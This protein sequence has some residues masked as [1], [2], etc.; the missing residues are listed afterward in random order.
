MPR[1]VWDLGNTTVRN[2][3]RIQEGLIVFAKHFQGNVYGAEQEAAFTRKL[4]DEGIISTAG[5]EPSWFGRKWRNVFVKLGFVTDKFNKGFQDSFKELCQD[6]GLSGKLYEL[7]PAGKLLVN[8]DS[9]G[10]ISDV[11]LRQ[12]RCLEIPS[13]IESSFQGEIMKP[14]IFLLQ[15]LFVLREREQSGLKKI[16]MAAFLQLFRKH[17]VAEVERTVKEILE[18]RQRRSEVSGRNN[19]KAFDRAILEAKGLEGGVQF[20]TLG[21]YADTTV[22][23]SRMTGLLSFRG[24]AI[25]LRENKLDIIKAI[26]EEE[27]RILHEEGKVEYLKEF[28]RGSSLPMDNPSF[29]LHEIGKLASQLTDDGKAVPKS[30]E[31]LSVETDVRILEKERYKLIELFAQSEEEKFA[32]EQAHEDSVTDI[33]EYLDAFA[34]GRRQ[35]MKHIVDPPTYLEWIVWRAFLAID[36]IAVPAHNTRRF[37][38]DEDMLPRHPAPGGGP[39]MIF[40]FDN[41]VLVIEVTLTSS[42]RQEAAEGETV[43]RHVADIV[44]ESDKEVYGLFLA[45][46]INSNTAETFR[47]DC[48][49]TSNDEEVEINIVPLTIGQLR[50]VLREFLKNPFHPEEL[51]K[52]IIS[53]LEYRH[54]RGPRWKNRID[55][56]A[57]EWLSNIRDTPVNGNRLVSDLFFSDVIP[58]GEDS[59]KYLPVYSLA[60]ACGKF[61]DG[62]EVKE[63]RWVFVDRKG[64]D[65][66]MFVVRA[67]GDSMEPRIKNGDYCI[68]KANPAGPYSQ[69]GGIYLFQYQGEPDPHTGGSYTIK[70]YQSHKG[71]DGF[72][73]RVELLPKNKS[74]S[75]LVFDQ[76]DGDISLKL[77]FVA[78]FVGI[79]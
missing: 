24:G 47:R 59:S 43:R 33:L 15:V 28:Y 26:L 23:Y 38:I 64:L 74:Y 75:P 44:K 30:A 40:E 73:I 53:C 8:A 63:D 45:P 16:E 54:E 37:L 42:S 3:N 2:P 72:N 32:I 62:M 46:D 12:L 34:T 69:R 31:N 65:E 51:L 48:W 50:D 35:A 41:F 7:T 52:L 70:G 56:L 57:N 1:R 19:L 36:H 66:T 20:G 77:H 39:D 55:S 11:F 29:A 22:R 25:V 5:S 21:D 49:Y 79:L 13:Q 60:A 4:H 76:K 61:A 9:S 27:P 67:V 58:E 14:F 71:E 6:L 18:Y 78:E 17:D 10:A 68:F